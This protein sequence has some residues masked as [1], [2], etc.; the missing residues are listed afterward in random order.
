VGGERGWV[1]KA[2]KSVVGS[3]SLPMAWPRDA[4]LGSQI[5]ELWKR[6]ST[7]TTKYNVFML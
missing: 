7:E 6:V 2:D 5:T 4:K 3:A 1:S